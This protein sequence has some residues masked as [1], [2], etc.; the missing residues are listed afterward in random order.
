MQYKLRSP[1]PPAFAGPPCIIKKVEKRREIWYNKETLWIGCPPY[2][3]NKNDWLGKAT[4]TV[5]KAKVN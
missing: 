4:T 5:S 3:I 1:H 2:D